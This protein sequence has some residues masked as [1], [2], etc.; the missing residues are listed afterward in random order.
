M[1]TGTLKRRK[2]WTS[3]PVRSHQWVG[4]LKDVYVGL[5]LEDS[6]W[7]FYVKS[8]QKR[9]WRRGPSEA[10]FTPTNTNVPETSA[11]LINVARSYTAFCYRAQFATLR[12]CAYKYWNF[13]IT[14]RLL[15]ERSFTKL[16]S[17][18]CA[19]LSCLHTDRSWRTV[20]ATTPS[21]PFITKFSAGQDVSTL[22]PQ[23]PPRSFSILSFFLTFSNGRFRRVSPTKKSHVCCRQPPQIIL[24]LILGKWPTWRTILYY[25]FIFIFNSTRFEHIVLIIRRDKL[26]QYNL[27]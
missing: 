2:K 19:W 3:I 5:K 24:L 22:R 13:M 25:V 20:Q 14:S 21:K 6:L 10:I 26:C 15:E 27:W 17:Q 4:N 18:L 16:S 23:Y 8:R 9:N 1:H 12:A 7:A 11:D